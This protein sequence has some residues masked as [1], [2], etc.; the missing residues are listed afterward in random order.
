MSGRFIMSKKEK[1]EVV[2]KNEKK[3]YVLSYAD[4]ICYVC[5]LVLCLVPFT[6][7]LVEIVMKAHLEHGSI[8][9]AT[10]KGDYIY[11]VSSFNTDSFN[12]IFMS[13]MGYMPFVVAV[14]IVMA[15][16]MKKNILRY[17]MFAIDLFVAGYWI[18]TANRVV[19][20]IFEGELYEP[21]AGYYMLLGAS[22]IPIIITLIALNKEKNKDNNSEMKKEKIEEQK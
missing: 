22:F 11:L 18:Y 3:K 12:N 20:K 15:T 17:I 8:G 9:Y 2:N 5:A 13:I 1:P 21:V 16:I 7:F 14:I 4:I 10:E 6:P 19:A